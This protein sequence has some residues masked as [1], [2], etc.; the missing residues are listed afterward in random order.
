MP[1]RKLD[2]TDLKILDVLQAS[3]RITNQ[4]LAERVAL[5]PSACLARLRALE[6]CGLIAGYRAQ[7]AIERVRPVMTVFAEVTMRRHDPAEF[8]RFDMLIEGIPEIVEASRISGAFDYLMKA[9]VGDMHEWRD[10]AIRLLKKDTGVDKIT[11]HVVMSEAKTFR[12]YP[13]A[14][15]RAAGN[16][17]GR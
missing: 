10:I 5:S 1:D 7:V 15:G 14:R 9:V 8:D 2:R 3:G 16:K 11:T 12:G 4:Q 6:A 17:A 13:L